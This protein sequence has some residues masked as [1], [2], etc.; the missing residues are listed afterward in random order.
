MSRIVYLAFPN[1]LAT[2]GQK[3]IL[4]HVE[5]LR[6][7]G[8]DAV[9]WRNAASTMPTAFQ[10]AAPVEVGTAFRD[11][12]ILVAPSDA[13]NAIQAIAGMAQASVIFC[14]AH[15]TLASMGFGA[16]DHYPADRPPTLMAVGH[17]EAA[18]LRRAYPRAR[19]E[20]VPCFADERI[21]KPGGP[22]QSQVACNVQKRRDEARL[23]ET[24]F[25]RLHPAMA[26]IPWTRLEG[27]AETEVARV[28]AASSL[29]LALGRFEA[30]GITA[31]EAMASGC[32]C[33]G[34]T[35][36]GGRDYATAENGFWVAEDDCY[37]AA[38]ALAQ[39]CDLVR[40]GGPA[41]ARRL[42]A[43]FE[44]ART[45]SYA[46]FRTALE[47]FWMRHGPQARRQS[48]PL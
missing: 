29:Y 14:Q 23:I 19:V 25:R 38:D 40:A 33:A 30:V 20:V 47:D 34:F 27:V 31:L 10:H 44:T 5:T 4:R 39:A 1:G 45:W 3:M 15:V 26:E 42:D 46:A 32:V 17:S 6:D 41:L 8:F 2:G 18:W 28:F 12:D 37:A 22:R 24:I 43:G 36:T 35:G 21:F 13:P 16:I 7:L 48:G 9:V 11:D